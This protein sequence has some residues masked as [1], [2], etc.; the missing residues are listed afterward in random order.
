MKYRL[1]Q[2]LF[3][4]PCTSGEFPTN[5]RRSALLRDL[6]LEILS[7]PHSGEIFP[8]DDL[9]ALPGGTKSPSTSCFSQAA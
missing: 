5:V 4:M 7:T 8:K 3:I 6:T 9:S 2:P 1:I